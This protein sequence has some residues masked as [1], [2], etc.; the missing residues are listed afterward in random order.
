MKVPFNM[1]TPRMKLADGE[2]V[3]HREEGLR[4]KGLFGNRFGELYV[5]NRRVAFV[6][7]IM[8]AGLI[9]AAANKLGATPIIDIDRTSIT[10]AEKVQHKK[11]VALVITAGDRTERFLI[12]PGAIEQVL[13]ALRT[14][15]GAETSC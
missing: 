5:T 11:Q 6:K 14:T 15:G 1:T 13:G 8:K 9:S 4:K 10:N 7:A 3:I 2:Q 12:E